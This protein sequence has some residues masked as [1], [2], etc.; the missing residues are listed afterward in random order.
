MA[1]QRDRKGK[2]PVNSITNFLNRPAS[3]P[4]SPNFQ[5]FYPHAS[6]S[7]FSSIETSNSPSTLAS[8]SASTTPAPQSTPSI[9]NKP[10]NASKTSHVWNYG[11]E[12]ID[13]KG[14]KRWRCD[15]CPRATAKTYVT[16]ATTNQR[17][18]LKDVHTLIDPDE[19]QDE[20]NSNGKQTKI[21]DHT[22]KPININVLRKLLVEWVVERRHAFSEI[23]SPGLR[24]ILEYLD[25]RSAK[26]FH[27]SNTLRA[28]CLR[29]LQTAK[30]EVIHTLSLAKSRIHLSFDLWT[31]PNYKAMIAVT[32]HWTD[33]NYKAQS[34]VLAIR[35]VKGEHSGENISET[36]YKVAQEFDIV[37]RIGYFVGD[38]AG[39]ND[40]ALKHLGRRI[41]ESGRRLAVEYHEARLRCFG[42]VI[43]LVVKRLLFGPKV[44]ELELQ[45]GSLT[46]EQKVEWMKTKWRAFGAVGKLHNVIKYIRHSPQR[47]GVFLTSCT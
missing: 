34:V 36:V 37:E 42:H 9:V 24:A 40:T 2:A 20:D 5:D 4:N 8:T 14:N 19:G 12:F 31:S 39:N 22:K 3:Q 28:D 27:T 26:A 7:S 15:V 33:Q 1:P 11:S 43:N 16:T 25:P 41:E 6:T 17:N 45:N 47:R 32:G 44:K 29:Y 13:K 38:N 18:H 10:K 30:S 21:D 46:L 23:E 35:E